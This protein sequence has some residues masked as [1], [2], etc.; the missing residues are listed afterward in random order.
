LTDEEIIIA[1]D[2]RNESAINSFL[3][4]AASGFG[5]SRSKLTPEKIIAVG[6]IH[7][8]VVRADTR[9][10]ASGAAIRRRDDN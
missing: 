4:H 6:R 1:D 5:K 2:S 7:P 8:F 3:K 10:I 9:V